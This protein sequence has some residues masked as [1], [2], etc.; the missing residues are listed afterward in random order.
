MQPKDYYV[1][2]I[3][4]TFKIQ[5]KNKPIRK[6][7]KDM[8]KYLLEEHIKLSNRHMKDVQH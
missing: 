6:L 3:L 4:I 8:N 7:A 1:E 2:C 5:Q